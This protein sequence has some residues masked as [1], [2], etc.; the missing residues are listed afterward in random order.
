MLLR[1]SQDTCLASLI[2]GLQVP[3]RE[4]PWELKR[5]RCQQASIHQRPYAG[6]VS[7]EGPAAVTHLHAHCL[8][9]AGHFTTNT[10]ECCENQK[11]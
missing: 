7:R 9:S 4:A 8:C 3:L 5:V 6:P 1:T 2:T 10:G 11:V